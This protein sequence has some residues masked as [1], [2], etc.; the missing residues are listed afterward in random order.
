L[1]RSQP[2]RTIYTCQL[3]HI[4]GRG[5][6]GV[7]VGPG[8]IS[9]DHTGRRTL[10]RAGLSTR[11]CECSKRLFGVNQ[12]LIDQLWNDIREATVRWNRWWRTSGLP[13]SIGFTTPSRM[14]WPTRFR[15]SKQL[16]V[17][18]GVENSHQ[19]ILNFRDGFGINRPVAERPS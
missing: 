3:A 7:D 9:L 18:P 5:Y 19:E 15:E 12:G 6:E 2:P 11:V 4:N 1:V 13:H 10:G 8:R 16:D 14:T 17:E